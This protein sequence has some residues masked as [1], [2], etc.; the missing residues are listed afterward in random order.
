M[1]NLISILFIFSILGMSQLLAHDI[2][3]TE[4]PILDKDKITTNT[5]FINL[6]SYTIMQVSAEETGR[7]VQ[8][9]N[10]EKIHHLYNSDQIYTWLSTKNGKDFNPSPKHTLNTAKGKAIIDRSTG[11]LTYHP[12]ANAKGTDNIYY[13]MQCLVCKDD[14]QKVLTLSFSIT[15]ND[16]QKVLALSFSTAQKETTE[17]IFTDFSVKNYPNPFTEK[18]TIQYILQEEAVVNIQLYSAMGTL[19][20]VIKANVQQVAGRHSF[21]LDGAQLPTG[22]HYVIIQS[23]EQ[24]ILHKIYK[25]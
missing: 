12:N 15:E 7:Y 24:R 18:T 4:F 9:T 8:L 22:M 16:G 21:N 5:N 11:I 3:A 20:K 14:S 1:K 13:K 10:E 23:E 2:Q 6:P 25:L 19:I 17:N